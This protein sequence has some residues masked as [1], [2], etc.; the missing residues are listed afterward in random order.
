MID[1][2]LLTTF[3]AQFDN[4]MLVVEESD[5]RIISEPIDALFYDNQNVFIKSYLV[6]ACSM[7]EAF[8]QDLAESYMLILQARVKSANLPYNFVTWLAEHDKAKLTFEVFEGKKTKKDISDMISPNYFRTLSAFQ[9]LGLDIYSE[10][11]FSYKDYISSIVDKR[12][13]IVHHNDAASDLSFS[14]VK[15]I[16]TE[17]KAY[18]EC[19]YQAVEA[20]PYLQQAG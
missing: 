16:I 9:R 18:A 17:F 15:A 2:A 10:Q 6:S 13:R 20:D 3:A 11:V 8:I 12:N 19:L 5:A 1:S 7:L 14:D 4:L